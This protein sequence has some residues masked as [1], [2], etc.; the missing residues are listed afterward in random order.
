MHRNGWIAIK[1]LQTLS[2]R[3]LKGL[4]LWE[5]HHHTMSTNP[6]YA[7]ILIQGVVKA[8]W[9]ETLNRCFIVLA[10]TVAELGRHLKDGDHSIE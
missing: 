5:W 9:Q 2:R 6:P 4:D 10:R 3:Y 1:A 7:R 8:L